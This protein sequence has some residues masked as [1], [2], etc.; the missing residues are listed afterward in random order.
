VDDGIEHWRLERA[1]GGVALRSWELHHTSRSQGRQDRL[2]AKREHGH[3]TISVC[4][5]DTWP[6]TAKA[7]CISR[8]FSHKPPAKQLRSCRLVLK[9]SSP[10]KQPNLLSHSAS[11]RG[12]KLEVRSQGRHDDLPVCPSR[13]VHPSTARTSVP[14]SMPIYCCR[15]YTK[16]HGRARDNAI[17]M[18][19]AKHSTSQKHAPMMHALVIQAHPAQRETRKNWTFRLSPAVSRHRPRFATSMHYLT[20]RPC[21]STGDL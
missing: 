2:V 7:R 6:S 18:E 14:R 8:P 16:D 9:L 20:T 15:C 3:G 17:P 5:L 1:G 12:W 4:D 10:R 13:H 19:A 11:R 21:W